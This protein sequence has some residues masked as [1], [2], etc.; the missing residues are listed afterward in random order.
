LLTNEPKGRKE[1]MLALKKAYD[2][3]S[4]VAHSGALGKNEQNAR[5]ELALGLKLCAAMLKI[6]IG[7]GGLPKDWDDL[8][9]GG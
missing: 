5:L 2:R 1:A 7:Q 9:L 4:S 6:V 8:V 3:R